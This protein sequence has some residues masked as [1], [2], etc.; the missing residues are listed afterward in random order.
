MNIK[1]VKQALAEGNGMAKF[2]INCPTF[3]AGWVA[4]AAEE[5]T[6]G[7]IKLIDVEK[8]YLNIMPEHIIG[9]TVIR[10]KECRGASFEEMLR[11]AMSGITDPPIKVRHIKELSKPLEYDVIK[12]KPVISSE[13]KRKKVQKGK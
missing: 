11:S 9:Y 13:K 7:A 3:D 2:F 6:T 12:G 5:A 8:D 10:A 1:Q 4:I